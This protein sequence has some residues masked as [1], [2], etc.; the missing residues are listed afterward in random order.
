[1]PSGLF[2]WDANKWISF[3]CWR[4]H[5]RNG[6]DCDA[7][8]GAHGRSSSSSPWA[9]PH[10][11]PAEVSTWISRGT[12]HLVTIPHSV[13]DFCFWES[14]QH[15]LVGILLGQMTPYVARFNRHISVQFSPLV[16]GRHVL[17]RINNCTAMVHSNRQGRVCSATLL[18][19]VPVFL[20]L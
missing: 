15:L 5:S 20:F 4:G 2:C 7:G 10:V 13:Q 3:R 19:L 17:V 8:V 1:M 11:S 16:W 18:K 9:V 6:T 12:R 14:H